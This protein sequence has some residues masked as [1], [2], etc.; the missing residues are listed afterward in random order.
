MG[1]SKKA[2]GISDH[3]MQGVL[4]LQKMAFSSLRVKNEHPRETKKE[5][6]CLSVSC[7]AGSEGKPGKEAETC[8]PP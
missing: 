1:G 4:C 6:K 7:Q 3:D 8:L 5:K 2:Y